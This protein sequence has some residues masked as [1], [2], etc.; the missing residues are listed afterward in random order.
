MLQE[1]EFMEYLI[2]QNEY[3]NVIEVKNGLVFSNNESQQL[4]DSIN[5]MAGWAGYHRKMFD[6]SIEHLSQVS[7][8][9]PFYLKSKFYEAFNYSYTDKSSKGIFVLQNIPKN[10]IGK[11]LESFRDF[12][13]CGMALLNR[14][15]SLFDSLY[16]SS[17][18][19]TYSY[20]EELISLAMYREDLVHVKH[21]SP[22]VAGL[23]SAIV[24]GSGKFYAGYRGQAISAAIPSVLIGAAA[25]ETYIRGGP[26]SPQFI[27]AASLFSVFYV[28]NIMG[29]AFSVKIYREEQYNEIDHSILVDLHIPLRRVFNK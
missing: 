7:L 22:F 15:Y 23:L 26:Q 25:I 13:L 8:N 2:G 4:L 11:D 10:S 5:Y 16:N 20:K 28:G 3:Q 9:S 24:P 17:D 12:E 21:K 1:I 6:Y 29:S 27:I 18:T 19:N 14:N